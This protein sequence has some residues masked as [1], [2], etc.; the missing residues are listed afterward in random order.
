MEK[1]SYLQKQCFFFFAESLV[2]LAFF[3]MFILAWGNNQRINDSL[4]RFFPFGE[5]PIN[6]AKRHAVMAI[7]SNLSVCFRGGQSH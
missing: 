2:K 1:F 4:F 7:T 5:R 6:P 3:Y